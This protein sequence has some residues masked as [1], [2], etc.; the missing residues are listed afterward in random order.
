MASIH[1]GPTGVYNVSFR[2]NGRQFLKSTKSE[3]LREARAVQARVDETIKALRIGRVEHPEPPQG[4]ELGDYILSGCTLA[5]RLDS[6]TLKDASEAYKLDSMD[7]GANTRK[8]EA[9]HL[10]HICR[11]IG[12]TTKLDRIDLKTL[13]RYVQDR[14]AKPTKGKGRIHKPAS[15]ATVHKELL[16]FT[17]LWTWAR[18]ENYVKGECPVKDANNPRKWAIRLPK[19]VEK[20]PFMTWG[21]IQARIK[22]E[23]IPEDKQAKLWARLYLDETEV[24]DLLAHVQ[25]SADKGRYA[26]MLAPF[27]LAADA[28]LRRSEIM[29]ALVSD[30]HLADNTMIVRERKRDKSKAGTTRVVPLTARLK[31]CLS[32]LLENRNNGAYLIVDDNGEPLSEDNASHYFKRMLEGS[33]W[34]VV[35]G[36]HTLRHSFASICLRK[37]IPI[38]VTAK[39]MGHTTM[40]MVELYQKVYVQDEMEWIKRLG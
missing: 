12:E 34:S 8:G 32:S 11:T 33:K 27:L 24:A 10:R 5:A 36:Y 35:K 9:K 39:W 15:G 37:G 7:K 25:E 28:G 6:I 31:T 19:T 2:W 23:N 30:V 20:E 29:N 18:R 38:Q 3:S 14:M 4:V 21:E 1:K 22:R 40:E 13:K 16:T 26:F 17:Q